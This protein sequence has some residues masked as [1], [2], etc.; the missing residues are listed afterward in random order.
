MK[1]EQG[2]KV[3]MDIFWTAARQVDDY[4]NGLH[5]RLQWVA[6]D[7]KTV[8]EVLTANGIRAQKLRKWSEYRLYFCLEA[9]LSNRKPDEHALAIDWA[10]QDTGEKTKRFLLVSEANLQRLEAFLKQR[11]VCDQ[12]LHTINMAGYGMRVL[13]FDLETMFVHNPNLVNQEEQYVRTL[14]ELLQE[15]LELPKPPEF[16]AGKASNNVKFSVRLYVKYE[17]VDHVE[18]D[19]TILKFWRWMWDR[20]QTDRRVE[21]LIV[22]QRNKDDAYLSRAFA[23]DVKAL[24]RNRQ[25]RAIDETKAGKRRFEPMFGAKADLHDMMPN[26]LNKP[27]P[28]RTK[29]EE[30]IDVY[31][32]RIMED[33]TTLK[34]IVH[35]KSFASPPP[36][37]TY[38]Y[39]NKEMYDFLSRY[40]VKKGE[41][42][43][44]MWCQPCPNGRKRVT[45][46]FVPWDQYKNELLQL[47]AN[48]IERGKMS[49]LHDTCDLKDNE[50]RRANV[51]VDDCPMD[52]EQIRQQYCSFAKIAVESVSLKVSS[53]QGRCH[54]IARGLVL[55][56]DDSLKEHRRQFDAWM[57]GKYDETQWR[58]GCVD[59]NPKNLRMLG[60]SKTADL[61]SRLRWDGKEGVPVLEQLRA[62]SIHNLDGTQPIELVPQQ[63]KSERIHR[64]GKTPGV[65]YNA[66]I[67]LHYLMASEITHIIGQEEQHRIA[68][69]VEEEHTVYLASG[70]CLTVGKTKERPTNTHKS[71]TAIFRFHNDK[72]VSYCFDPDCAAY[73]KAH[74]FPSHRYSSPEAIDVLFGPQ[75]QVITAAD[76]DFVP[77]APP[78]APGNLVDKYITRTCCPEDQRV[79]VMAGNVLVFP[80]GARVTHHQQLHAFQHHSDSSFSLVPHDLYSGNVGPEAPFSPQTTRKSMGL[81]AIRLGWRVENC[82]KFDTGTRQSLWECCAKP[83]TCVACGKSS[84]KFL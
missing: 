70:F 14:L 7:A 79:S 40:K 11:P 46:F 62:C 64:G 18:H 36:E 20:R 9:A 68:T 43:N 84:P 16:L 34:E 78:K 32:E 66:E 39:Q 48:A 67:R 10:H 1:V 42:S 25:L 56:N 53:T 37:C 52:P 63:P 6:E 82:V 4:E 54:L 29:E 74:G 50:P 61:E 44:V 23:I 76:D 59:V 38:L 49:F 73:R 2:G 22:I 71:H 72:I 57:C 19:R 24:G 47:Q 58:R 75:W 31:C 30:T 33:Q 17:T 15:F 41:V 26:N 51:D 8:T 3:G 27:A 28:I 69:I 65:P 60:S 45:R 12:T 81:L 5:I 21:S 77:Q 80:N 83:F 13:I 35:C 55:A